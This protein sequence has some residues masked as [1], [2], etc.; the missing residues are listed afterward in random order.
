MTKKGKIIGFCEEKLR[1]VL[2]RSGIECAQPENCLQKSY[3]KV[4]YEEISYIDKKIKDQNLFS[5]HISFTSLRKVACEL[6]LRVRGHIF[7]DKIQILAYADDV[8][9]IA[10][11]EASLQGAYIALESAAKK[12]SWIINIRKP[13]YMTFSNDRRLPQFQ[14]GDIALK[15]NEQLG[16]LQQIKGYASSGLSLSEQTPL[17]RTLAKIRQHRIPS[18]V[19]NYIPVEKRNVRRS[20]NRWI[21]QIERSPEFW[22]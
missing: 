14:D 21:D 22:E 10:R 4:S 19:L 6:G 5:Q 2:T 1:K 9:F 8:D 17:D 11:S 16:I 3:L 7:N 12:M 18:K 13:K 15:K 20:K